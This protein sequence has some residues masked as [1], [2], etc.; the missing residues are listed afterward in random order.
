MEKDDPLA[1]QDFPGYFSHGA[2]V[3]VPDHFLQ[4]V[5]ILPGKTGPDGMA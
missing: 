5:I 1:G 2:T 3:A 4:A